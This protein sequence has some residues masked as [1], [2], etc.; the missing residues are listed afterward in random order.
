MR[1]ICREIS[2]LKPALAL[3]ML[4][5]MAVALQLP[6]CEAG[7]ADSLITESQ[8]PPEQ[9]LFVGELYASSAAM[10]YWWPNLS[11]APDSIRQSAERA[12]GLLAVVPQAQASAFSIT[13]ATNDLPQVALWLHRIGNS[14]LLIYNHGHSGLPEAS[15]QYVNRFLQVAFLS[16]H[17]VLLTS[18]PLTGLN[19]PLADTTY[20]VRTRDSEELIPVDSA[21][22]STFQH[23]FY[24]VIDDPD[25]Y[26][27]Y[28]IDAGVIPAV[29]LSGASSQWHAASFAQPGNTLPTPPAYTSISYVGLSGGATTGLAT[30][31]VLTLRRCVLIAGVMP[32]DLR[33]KYLENFGDAEQQSRSIY[34][35]FT[36]S[37]LLRLAEQS[38]DGLVLLYNEKDSCCFADP[39]ATEFRQRYP[40]YDIRVLPL[41]YHGYEPEAVLGIL[42]N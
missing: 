40:Q 26:L 9:Q 6:G 5:T 20:H 10:L 7:L 21:V 12:N 23:A 22:L 2:G 13:Y 29:F 14:Q 19:A 42:N 8:V 3:K 38:S 1:N 18:M 11:D 41:D 30:C 31:A 17:D 25:S 16:G 39:S 34:E 35:R 33:V 36:V 27:H 32:V 24:E 4:G 28:F 37:R 15:E